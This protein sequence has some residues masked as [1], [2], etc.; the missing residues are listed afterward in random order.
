MSASRFFKQDR[1]SNFCHKGFKSNRWTFGEDNSRHRQV[2]RK[3]VSQ[4]GYSAFDRSRASTAG[5]D[6]FL[7]DDYVFTTLGG[8]RR[9]WQH[10]GRSTK[11]RLHDL[12]LS[13]PD[14]KIKGY[15]D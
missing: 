14:E 15:L 13:D 12:D 10:S 6:R 8:A 9:P 3:T 7:I 1:I 4:F 11:R 5:S 2:Y